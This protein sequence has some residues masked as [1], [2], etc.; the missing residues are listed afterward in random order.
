MAGQSPTSRTLQWVKKH[1]MGEAEVVEKYNS[2]TKT[3]KDLFGIIDILLIKP[4]ATVGLQVTSGS[5]HA[6]RLTKAK[7]TPQVRTWLD[8]TAKRELLVVSWRKNAKGR[9][10]VR[11]TQLRTYG[12]DWEVEEVPF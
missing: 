7:E 3:R 2:F 8:G 9:W 4:H 6:A 1:E 5:N 12:L 11:A 10:T